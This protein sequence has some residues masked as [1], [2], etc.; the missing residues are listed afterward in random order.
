MPYFIFF[1]LKST[2]LIDNTSTIRT[3]SLYNG[4][5]KENKRK[6]N[7]STFYLRSV[8]H[9]V[10]WLYGPVRELFITPLTHT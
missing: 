10:A 7:I 3:L 6:K 5:Q 8:S 4:G 2:I 1:F 9:K